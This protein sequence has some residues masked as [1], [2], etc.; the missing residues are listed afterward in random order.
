M[1]R[2]ECLFPHLR[3]YSQ[4]N[5]GQ[6]PTGGGDH[7]AMS[8]PSHFLWHNQTGSPIWPINASLDQSMERRPRPFKRCLYKTVFHRIVMEIIQVIFIISLITNCVFPKTGLPVWLCHAPILSEM[9]SVKSLYYAPPFREVPVFF[10]QGPDAVHVVRHQ[11]PCVNL[12]RAI[13][14][15]LFDGQP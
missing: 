8:F 14:L 12:E 1:I 3:E 9:S 6:R 15:T 2:R 10:V 4:N 5:V 7:P 11:N 13:F